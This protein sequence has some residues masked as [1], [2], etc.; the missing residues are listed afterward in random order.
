MI[1]KSE[2][3]P[4]L[5]DK[6]EHLVQFY[7]LMDS[8]KMKI[9]SKDFG[10]QDDAYTHFEEMKDS[11]HLVRFTCKI[12]GKLPET[13]MLDFIHP[14]EMITM[15]SKSYDDEGMITKDFFDDEVKRS[16]EFWRQDY[17]L[18]EM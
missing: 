13:S 15:V 18:Q 5:L 7:Y 16:Y 1:L 8:K 3:M 6:G 4:H 11:C 2:I 9:I 14:L 10:Y 17:L 12:R